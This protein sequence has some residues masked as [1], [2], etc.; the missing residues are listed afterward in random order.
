[1][2]K[3]FSKPGSLTHKHTLVKR[4]FMGKLCVKHMNNCPA[5]AVFFLEFS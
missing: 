3:T 2:A 4:N 1:M 5:C